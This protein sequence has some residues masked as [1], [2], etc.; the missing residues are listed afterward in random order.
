MRFMYLIRS[1]KEMC[2]PPPQRLMEEIAKISQRE[3]EAGRMIDSGGLLPLAT[4]ARVSLKN[5]KVSVIDGPFAEAKEIIGGYAVFEFPTKE[6][7]LASAVEFM[8]LHQQYG[9][10][11]EGECEMRLMM[12]EG[13][14]ELQPADTAGASK[15]A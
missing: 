14:C 6:E 4:G 8:N 7:A 13:V 9:E 1:E 11:W 10:G 3:I 12:T 15:A 5:G 2:G